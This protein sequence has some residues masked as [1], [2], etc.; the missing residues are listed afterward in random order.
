MALWFRLTMQNSAAFIIKDSARAQ[1]LHI[2]DSLGARRPQKTLD[3]L[4]SVRDTVAELAEQPNLGVSY[5]M[6]N[7]QL[8]SLRRFRVRNHRP[9]WIY[10]RPFVSGNGIEVFSVVHEKQNIGEQ[11]EAALEP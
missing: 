9:Y 8:H 6:P 7:P 10:Y 1:I 3:W 2:S 5:P 4:A 11:L